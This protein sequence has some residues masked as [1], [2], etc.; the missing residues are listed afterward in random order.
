M[1][2]SRSVVLPTRR[3]TYPRYLFHLSPV[4]N[5]WVKLSISDILHKIQIPPGFEGQNIYFYDG[6]PI[7]HFCVAGL[8]VALEEGERRWTL[9]R[10]SHDFLSSQPT[11][12]EATIC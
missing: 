6:H 8:V 5:T 1:T 9:T 12:A 4:F 7:Q 2:T 3:S 11:L 10:R